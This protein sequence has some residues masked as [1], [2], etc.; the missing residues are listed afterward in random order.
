MPS[1]RL[2]R[3]FPIVRYARCLPAFAVTAVIFS[4]CG[5]SDSP[6]GALA[7]AAM[8]MDGSA[9][10]AP[11]GAPQADGEAGAPMIV[12]TVVVSTL[13]DLSNA[14]LAPAPGSTI[15]LADGTYTDANLAFTAPGTATQ[16][17]VIT[18]QNPG[19]AILA[20]KTQISMGGS[21]VTLQG[22][23]LKGGQSSG[24]SLVET[25]NGTTFCND[26]RVTDLA[27]VDVDIGNAADT[28]WVSLYGQR[29]RVD[30]CVF[31]GKTNPGTLLVVWRQLAGRSDD[32]DI[33]HN[34]FANRPP[35]AVP[36]N[37]NEAIRV[38]TGAE[39]SSDSNTRIQ[40][41]L[42][43][44]MSG[45][46][47]VIS[48]KSGAN[49]IRSNTITRSVGTLTLRNGKGSTVDANIIL[50]GGLSGAG[51]IRV[52]GPN[53]RI[54]NNYV[55]GVRSSSAAR[56][57]LSLVS[58][59]SN[60]G[61]GQYAQVVDALVAFNTVVDCDQSLIF[62][63]D[64][65]PLAPK[66]VTFANNLIASARTSVVA[67]GVG[68]ITPTI[69]GNLYIGAPLGFSPGTGF[70]EIDP[71]LARAADGLM[72]PSPGSPA[73]GVAQAGTDVT[74]D[75]DGQTRTGAFDV[76]CDQVGALGPT[77]GPLTRSNVGPQRWTITV[78]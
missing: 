29:D 78:P 43:E 39:A 76:G 30:H 60:P 17:I 38:G 65:N 53:H 62:G 46:A 8:D 67:P 57:G 47:E 59:M 33:D 14:L 63:A 44:A 23:L 13:T 55:E 45:D 41:N 49:V 52:I 58:G 10:A 69:F 7:D 31:S 24:P 75:I 66:N 5:G 56:G 61:P 64:S 3:P 68:L 77:R 72:R 40:E 70:T 32:D 27:I 2:H 16:P 4:G 48:V 34:L 73:I 11:E 12:C 28:K 37:G 50:T 9:D 71:M 19:R 54:T 15:C 25:K 36:A 20:G 21:F 42:F 18:A 6:Q 51:G 26:C 22:L 35:L 1:K 74:T